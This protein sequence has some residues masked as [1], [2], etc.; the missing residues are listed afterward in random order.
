MPTL[1]FLPKFLSSTLHFQLPHQV[2]PLPTRNLSLHD[3]TLHFQISQRPKQHW[4]HVTAS[5]RMPRQLIVHSTSKSP[6]LEVQIELWSR[7]YSECS[8]KSMYSTLHFQ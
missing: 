2:G 7:I 1:R 4:V 8:V 6:V 5:L 3:C